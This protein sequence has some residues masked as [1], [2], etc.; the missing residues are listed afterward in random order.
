MLTPTSLSVVIRREHS[1]KDGT[2]PPASVI[3]QMDR[4]SQMVLRIPKKNIY[5]GPM[6]LS[7]T[8]LRK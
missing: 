4:W 8:E 5:R 1:R 3:Q 7:S 6:K 2:A